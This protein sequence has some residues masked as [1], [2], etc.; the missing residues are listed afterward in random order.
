MPD[1]RKEIERLRL[2]AYVL[3]RW[4]NG[5]PQGYNDYMMSSEVESVR[6]IGDAIN[7]GEL[8]IVPLAVNISVG[9]RPVPFELTEEVLYIHERLDAA[10]VALEARMAR[11]SSA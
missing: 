11:L 5:Q 7:R 3:E 2:A 4:K 8:S 1:P 9:D 10:I 6:D